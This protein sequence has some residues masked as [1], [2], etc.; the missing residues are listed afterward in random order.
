MLV[1]DSFLVAM[2]TDLS[3][4]IVTQISRVAPGASLEV[5]APVGSG[6]G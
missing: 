3:G 4:E 6:E 2:G 1:G 5:R